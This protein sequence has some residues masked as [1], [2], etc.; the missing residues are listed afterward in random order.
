MVA[1][2]G[3]QSIIEALVSHIKRLQYP[4]EKIEGILIVEDDVVDPQTG[5]EAQKVLD[6]FDENGLFRIERV[7]SELQLPQNKPRALVW[8]FWHARPASKLL[9]IYDAED[10]PEPDQLLKAVGMH[11]AYEARGEKVGCLQARLAF[12]NPRGSLISSFYDLEY[13]TH[14]K[15]ILP[16]LVRLNLI[17][18]LGGTS[19]IFRREA[20]EAVARKNPD[21]SG[22]LS[23]K[24]LKDNIAKLPLKGAHDP[25]NVT[26]DAA[27]AYDLE[28]AGYSTKMLDSVTYEEAPVKWNSARKQRSRWLQ[29]YL[30]T[31]LVHT[32][33]PV[34]TM[35]R[36]GW[37]RG[38][39]QYLSFNLL[40]LGAPLSFLLGPV[41]WAIMFVYI[42]ARLDHLLVVSNYI[43]GLFP[44]PVYI[45]GMITFLLGNLILWTQVIYAPVAQQE[46]A[47]RSKVPR[48]VPAENQHMEEYGLVIRALL[49]PVFWMFTS[50]AAIRA[51]R[52]LMTPS[53]RSHWDKTHHG[54][55]RE[56]LAALQ[57]AALIELPAEST[58]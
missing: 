25:Y 37:S 28:K 30:Q 14:F 33:T 53:L 9:V 16:G 29:G 24:S 12:W 32:R 34:R 1:L 51:V 47:E 46:E 8:G 55:A 52:K 17:P 48:S 26:E 50:L 3:E 2:K 19:N 56:K 7:P 38:L 45:V 58:A 43:E 22:A 36:Y 4:A 18:P 13:Y 21:W 15:W 39:A 23:G 57:E 11:R 31:F 54:H 6:E 41:V 42:A 27:I 10:I 5:V 35:R 44:A 49:I 40:M 20:L